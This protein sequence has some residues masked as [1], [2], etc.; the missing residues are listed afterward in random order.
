[1][2]AIWSKHFITAG[3]ASRDLGLERTDNY[4]PDPRVSSPSGRSFGTG[5]DRGHIVPAEDMSRINATALDESFYTT[6]IVPQNPDLNR[7]VW[8]SLEA[9]GR[10]LAIKHEWLGVYSGAAYRQD[11]QAS[12]SSLPSIPTHLWKV[13]MWTSENEMPQTVA[14]LIPNI[15]V[16]ANALDDYLI[17]LE[18]LKQRIG[19]DPIL[20]PR[21]LG[22]QVAVV[23]ESTNTE[24]REHEVPSYTDGSSDFLMPSASGGLH[25]AAQE[26]HA[27]KVRSLL[28]S[29]R[30]SAK[31][32]HGC[33]PL[34]YAAMSGD[35]AT[36]KVLLNA[37]M[38]TYADRKDNLGRVPLHYAAMSG[39]SATTK[40]LLDTWSS[41]KWHRDKNGKRPIDLATSTAVRVLLA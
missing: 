6:N 18:A 7:G 41:A 10:N 40:V 31:D 26:G 12:P 16:S 4:R 8:A 34:H 27:E 9:K 14:W 5:Y 15:A 2:G 39:D 29:E 38:S 1:M 3:M 22:L 19:L 24:N 37:S 25:R 28:R 30:T 11:S 21:T 13:F 36:V 32:E 33:V 20:G 17:D 35:S 23:T